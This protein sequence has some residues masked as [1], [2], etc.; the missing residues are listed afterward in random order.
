MKLPNRLLFIAAILI[1]ALRLAPAQTLPAPTK[2]AP[3]KLEPVRVTADLWEA[4]LERISASVSV[5]DEMALRAGAI[6]HLGDLAEIGRAH[7]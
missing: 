1:A 3:V 4:P 7:V 2:A 5:Y 6:R